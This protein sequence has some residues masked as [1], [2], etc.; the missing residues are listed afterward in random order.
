[1]EDVT[2]AARRNPMQAV[3]IGASIAYPLLKLARAIPML[4]LLMARGCFSQVPRP[5]KGQSKR[6]PI[7][8]RT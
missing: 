3:A 1:V 7:W 2:A 4:V 8:H 5:G 6:P